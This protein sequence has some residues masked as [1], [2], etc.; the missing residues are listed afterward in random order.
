MN[1]TKYEF[2]NGPQANQAYLYRDLEEHSEKPVD[3]T[4]EHPANS[5]QN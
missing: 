3:E 5:N 4:L 2:W 1:L